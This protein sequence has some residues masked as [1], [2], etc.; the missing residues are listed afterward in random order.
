MRFWAVDAPYRNLARMAAR[1]TRS[2]DCRITGF[3]PGSGILLQKLCI[4]AL[5]HR[6]AAPLLH[7]RN[8]TFL[9]SSEPA[10]DIT[11]RLSPLKTDSQSR[12]IS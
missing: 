8:R 5:V 9:W 3:W 6:V 2:S 12:V 11:S 7:R 4:F 1:S 10:A